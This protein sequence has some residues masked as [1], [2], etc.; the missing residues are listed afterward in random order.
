M[1]TKN[2]LAKPDLPYCNSLH[3]LSHS[4]QRLVSSLTPGARKS[5]WKRLPK[6]LRIIPPF[7]LENKVYLGTQS[8]LLMFQGSPYLPFHWII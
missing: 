7:D 8:W 2:G 4:Y 6:S 1:T 3:F 5:E